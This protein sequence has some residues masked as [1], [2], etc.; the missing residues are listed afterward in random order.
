MPSISRS[1]MEHGEENNDFAVD[2]RKTRVRFGA[3]QAYS[4]PVY[5]ASQGES[6]EGEE[7]SGESGAG[8]NGQGES[9]TLAINASRGKVGCCYY[10]GREGVV[11]MMEDTEDSAWDLVKTRMLNVESTM[12]SLSTDQ[13]AMLTRRSTRADPADSGTHFSFS[14][15]IISRRA[16]DEFIAFAFSRFRRV[17]DFL[18]GPRTR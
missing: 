5:S 4:Q 2:E 7:E 3:D 9:T 15:S 10:S 14:G 8:W 17:D 16:L 12:S 1:E 11:Y 6:D 18:R 13:I